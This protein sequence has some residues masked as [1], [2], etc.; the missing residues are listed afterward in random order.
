MKKINQK[1]VSPLIATVLIVA[2]TIAVAVIVVSSLTSVTKQQTEAV[3]AKEG[4]AR[5]ALDIFAASCTNR[6]VTA[7]IQNI[8]TVD[9]TNFTIF[10]N[11]NNQ[12]STNTTPDG[13]STVLAPGQILTLKANMTYN[14]TIAKLRVSAGNCPVNIEITNS[15]SA[16]GTC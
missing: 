9:L 10:A 12:L 13:G 15:S 16:I 4:C 11:I 8:G 6:S 7:I 14:G 2:F 1:A 5:G 3:A